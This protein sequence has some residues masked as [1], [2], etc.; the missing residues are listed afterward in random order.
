MIRRTTSRLAI[1]GL[2]AVVAVGVGA[3]PAHA[4]PATH[5]KIV[6][7]DGTATIPPLTECPANGTASIDLAF[8]DVF[9]LT[10]TDTTF[11]VHETQTG[12]FTSRSQT[13][14]VL[15]TGHF[16]NSFS[17][18]GPGFPKETFTSVINANGKA[19]DGSQVHV[20][21]AQHFT[22]TPAGDVTVSFTKISCG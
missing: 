2:A 19:T 1:A 22:I 10:F 12:T 17:N 16:T 13:G 4:V 21:I 20:H 6:I 8:H 15:A 7:K 14:A 3:V 11:H 9:H 18:Q 5:E